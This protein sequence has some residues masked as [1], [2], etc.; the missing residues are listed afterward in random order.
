[1]P[2]A[3]GG[4]TG[5]VQTAARHR[6]VDFKRCER[7]TM[8]RNLRGSFLLFVVLAICGSNIVAQSSQHIA[9]HA[10]HV[11]DVT[12]GKMLPDQLLLIEGV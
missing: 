7:E 9:I 6:S 4:W 10:G 8:L 3:F 2:D 11:L 1:M 5:A 12:T